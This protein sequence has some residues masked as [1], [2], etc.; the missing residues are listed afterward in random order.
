MK[1]LTAILLLL[2]V[3]TPMNVLALSYPPNLYHVGDRRDLFLKGD[4]AYL[5]HSGTEEVRKTIH[6]NDVLIV[7]RTTQLCEITE[8]GRIRIRSVVGENY[9]KGEVLEGEIR[10]DDIARKGNVS[11]LVISVGICSHNQ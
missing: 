8:V 7:Y 5:F 1:K 10:P 3:I 11:C 6:L 9:F 2:A 4:V